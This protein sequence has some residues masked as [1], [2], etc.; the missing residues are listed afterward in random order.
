MARKKRTTKQV[1]RDV[2]TLDSV[3]TG[4]ANAIRAKAETSDP[5]Y[6]RNMGN[7]IRAIK[8]IQATSL[9]EAN[10]PAVLTDIANAIRACGVSGTMTISQMIDNIELL[11]YSPT[12]VSYT[13]ASGLSDWSEYTSNTI[14]GSSSSP[15]Y[16]TQIPNVQ[17]A[18]TISIGGNVTELGNYAFRGCNY[19]ATVTIPNSVTSV[20][21][22]VF[23]GCS[24]LVNVTLPSSITNINN[25][26]FSGCTS[27]TGITIPNSVT[28]IG[29]RAFNNCSNLASITIPSGVTSIAIGAFWGCSNLTSLTIPS[30]VTTISSSVCRGC[31]SLTEVNL[32]SGITSIGTYAF[33]GACFP[34]IVMPASVTSISANCFNGCS[35]CE[36]FDFR[37]AQSIP[38]LDTVSAFAN[39]SATKE[40]VVPDSLYDTWIATTNWSS[41]T[42]NIVNCIVKASQSSLGTL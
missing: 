17:N 21:T 31:S 20:G 33:Y 37:S 24:S 19:L 14:S 22:Y 9:P 36:I 16:T 27:L 1:S 32:P 12:T 8:N 40:I 3:F 6:P 11:S 28:S 13:Q 7:A 30:G 4:I 18:Q 29:A 42:N 15:Y 34:S 5:I 2:V 26:M 23:Y 38:T 25:Y 39:T 41:T 10:L 35:S